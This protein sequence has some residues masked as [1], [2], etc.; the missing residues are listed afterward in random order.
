MA[1]TP[2]PKIKDHQF[3]AVQPFYDLFKEAFDKLLKFTAETEAYPQLQFSNDPSLPTIFHD[4][5][6]SVNSIKGSD[7]GATMPL[8]GILVADVNASQGPGPDEFIASFIV[9]TPDNDFD[10]RMS[11]GFHD[12]KEFTVDDLE[13]FLKA[14]IAMVDQYPH[15]LITADPAELVPVEIPA[16]RILH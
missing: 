1:D 12:G 8:F 9:Y 14:I 15:E 3:V 2:N 11:I 5:L 13:T 10:R 7:I 6:F 4:R 16:K